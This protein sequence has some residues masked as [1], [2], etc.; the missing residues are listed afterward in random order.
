[1]RGESETNTRWKKVFPSD[2]ASVADEGGAGNQHP[3]E[4]GFSFRRHFGG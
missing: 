1:M 3:L 2:A 4:E